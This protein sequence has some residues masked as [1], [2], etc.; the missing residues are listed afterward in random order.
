MR[1]FGRTPWPCCCCRRC[2]GLGTSVARRGLLIVASRVPAAV[3][4][5]RPGLLSRG[6]AVCVGRLCGQG[7]VAAAQRKQD[8]SRATATIVTLCGLP[9]ARIDGVEVVQAL[10]GAV[11]RSAGRGRAVRPGG[12]GA[13]PDAGFAGVVPGGLDQQ[14]AGEHRSGL[15]DRSVAVGLAGLLARW[16]Q[17]EP[18]PDAG[19]LL[20][21]AAQSAPSSRWIASAVS[22]STPRNARSRATV[23]H[24]AGSVASHRDPLRERLLAGGQPIDGRDQV[25]E[26]E[27]RHRLRE[28]LGSQPAAMLLGPGRGLG[29][30]PAVTQQ[31]LRDA[32]ACVHQIPAARV[33]RA[34]QLPGGL[35]LRGKA[36]PPRSATPPS[37]TARA[38]RRPCD[39]S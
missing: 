22:V 7:A 23:G 1:G 37:D 2:A 28:L 29:I 21:T 25:S 11:C 12:C 18:G 33:M 8:S 15:G 26:G 17:P 31:H 20:E 32:V 34:H 16:G 9:R 35:H 4:A 10:L 30:H 13:S 14:P 36:P 38:A 19:G 3:S 5:R 27:R 24:H 6:A 39:R